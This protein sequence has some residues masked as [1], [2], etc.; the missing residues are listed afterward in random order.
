[1]YRSLF[2][3]SFSYSIRNSQLR[4]SNLSLIFDLPT[5]GENTVAAKLGQTF[6]RNRCTYVGYKEVVEESVQA[7]I[8]NALSLG[9]RST[10]SSLLQD[11]SCKD[12]VLR[13]DDFLDILKYCARL[14]DPLFVMETWRTMQLKEVSMSGK[15]YLLIT[16]ALCKG[17]YIEEVFN[18]INNLSEN[19]DIYPVLPMYNNLLHVCVE[20]HSV[21]HVI[22]CL[23]LMEKQ[24]V[25][26]NEATYMQLLKFAVLQQKLSAVYDI[27][28]ECNK[29]YNPSI[30]VLNRFICSFANLGDL[31][32]AY[33]VLQHMLGLL[34]QGGSIV[35]TN[36]K[37]SP[38]TQ[39]LDIPIP[40]Y[41][42]LNLENVNIDNQTI[43]PSVVEHCNEVG[44]QASDIMQLCTFDFKKHEVG[45]VG[46]D[47]LSRCVSVPVLQVLR[48]SFNSV[49]YACAQAKNSSLAEHIIL[50]MQNLGVK[51]SSSTYVGFMRA[52]VKDK[53]AQAGIE[54]LKSM[55]NKNVQPCDS[56]F[57]AISIGCSLELKVD[58]AES[59]LDQ[60]S[61]SPVVYP[62]NS[63]L[64]ACK[65]LDQPERA[66]R[67][68]AKMRHKE[69]RPNIRTYELMFSLFGFVN[70]PY[71]S[72]DVQ[73]HLDAAKRISAIE[74]DMLKN[75]FQ[76]SSLSIAN[77]LR[78]LGAERMINEL[79]HYLRVAER[80]FS[81][82]QKESITLIYN[83]VLH[84]LVKA[85]ET[86]LAAETFRTMIN[87][88]YQPDLATY[89]TMIDCCSIV[90]G[91]KYACALVSL[92]I[93]NGFCPQGATYTALTKILLE[94]VHL[95]NKDFVGALNLLD[96]ACSEDIQLDILLFNTILREAFYQKKLV[97]IELVL[98]RMHE[99]KILPDP[100]T[101]SYVFR[102]YV[103]R[104]RYSTALEALQVLS[105]RMILEDGS[106]LEEMRSAYEQQFILAEDM[107]ADSR[108]IEL[109][110][111]RKDNLAS[112]LLN[113][114]WCAI[115]G[116]AI[117]WSPDQS[118]WAKRLLKSYG[119][120]KRGS[121]IVDK[122][123]S[124]TYVS[125]Q[126]RTIKLLKHTYLL[127]ESHGSRQ[128]G[129]VK[130]R[131]KVSQLYGSRKL[132]RKL[133]QLVGSR[134]RDSSVKCVST[135]KRS[136]K[137]SRLKFDKRLQIS[138][139]LERR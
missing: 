52:V 28:K 9:D 25:G 139:V 8:V 135:G 1:M 4:N 117:S 58:L 22:K 6:S 55:Q 105:M 19:S 81:F 131:K 78:A 20:T 32:A 48:A 46:T 114:R 107:E 61:H 75:G 95:K 89:T 123:L 18:L 96:M 67:I 132:R 50:Q 82:Y 119:C 111:D 69:L 5:Y 70:A 63:C 59:Y 41:T 65:I 44:T 36:S 130:R 34:L 92:M 17:G 68:L 71:E 49:I 138:Q 83:A 136:K 87:Y 14:P 13:A 115:A 120:G 23:D 56:I 98:Q 51:P 85:E 64:E 12:S 27:W 79:M 104:G 53:G 54:L 91:F 11:V 134:K 7:K 2:S 133:A 122:K 93:R 80:N 35:Q 10:A 118:L 47:V 40:S 129:R 121:F 125:L 33:A 106:S 60:M 45:N 90:G 127:R 112:G 72:G 128:W 88:G 16:R 97:V 126:R 26:K 86:Q 24:M 15:C 73:S 57:A 21:N 101:C 74:A 29:Y 42:A 31:S 110:K 102:A 137:P 103:A 108:I 116:H 39:R 30:I 3:R 43:V 113:L 76:H 62:Y 66:T 94:N 99:K 38:Y 124:D 37:G 77:L 100:T 109:F 84:S